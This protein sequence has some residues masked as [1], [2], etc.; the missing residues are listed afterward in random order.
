M[1]AKLPR[2]VRHSFL[3]SMSLPN[4]LRDVD[5]KG[6][7]PPTHLSEIEGKRRGVWIHLSHVE[8]RLHIVPRVKHCSRDIFVLTMQH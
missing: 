8:E 6:R 5:T 4:T 7:H 2:L 1:C 3:V